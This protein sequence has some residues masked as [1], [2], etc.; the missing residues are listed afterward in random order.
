MEYENKNQVKKKAKCMEYM[1]EDFQDCENKNNCRQPKI[2]YR[3]TI[4]LK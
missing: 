1:Y 4:I 2:W 3:G